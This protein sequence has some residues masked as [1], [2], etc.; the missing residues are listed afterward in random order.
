VAALLVS[1]PAPVRG[2]E[3]DGPEPVYRLRIAVRT[4][5]GS[6]RVFLGSP[7]VLITA[8]AVQARGDARTDVGDFGRGPLLLVRRGTAARGRAV[9]VAAIVVEGARRVRFRTS[10]GGPGSVLVRV[11]NQN[12]LPARP[13]AT[14]RDHRFQIDPADVTRRGPVP[15]T[16]PMPPSVL[17]YYY[18][19]YDLADWSGG[20]PI[21]PDNT[22]PAPYASSDPAAIDRQIQQARDAGI[23]GFIV[24]WWGREFWDD[25]AQLVLERLPPGFSFALYVE[26]FSPSFQTE[27]DLIDQIDYAL[28]TY[29]SSDRYLRIDGRPVLYAFSTHN[30]MRQ[31]GTG[32]HPSYRD[33]WQRVLTGVAS[34]GHDPLV[35][36]EGRPFDV[37]DF[38]LFGGMH[39]YGTEDPALTPARDRRMALTA[40]AWAAV[41]GG[42]RRIWGA[43]VLPG[44][45]DRHIAGRRPDF[46]PR[47]DGRL[48][49]AQWQAA[50][51]SASDQVLVVSFNE[52]M[53]TT[54][55]EPNLEWGDRYLQLTAELSQ[56]YRAS[57]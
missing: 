8:E 53:E 19:W 32:P 27:G 9:F 14:A 24:S 22:N 20:K 55:I 36:G 26:V 6:A 7:A 40:R 28:D 15:G 54:N 45:D 52:W 10:T 47:E 56:R 1:V 11:A 51:D 41:H 31:L 42:P 12:V 5:A 13:I 33:V 17:A 23:D 3:P 44:Y 29:A 18:P 30:V 21:A 57:S 2:E 48:Y 34:R 25:N 37:D 16:E 49:E 50:I 35:I 4:T 43:S 38:D 46:F 39:V